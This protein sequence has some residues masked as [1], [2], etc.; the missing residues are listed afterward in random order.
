METKES[1]VQFSPH[2]LELENLQK[3]FDY[4]KRAKDLVNF[5]RVHAK[6]YQ[7]KKYIPQH[8][9]KRPVIKKKVKPFQNFK[10]N[11]KNA[12]ASKTIAEE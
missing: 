11:S 4:A 2:F 10:G 3:D 7:T 8:Q 6:V 1:V 12:L 9:P 5:E